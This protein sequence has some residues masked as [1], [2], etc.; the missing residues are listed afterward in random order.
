MKNLFQFLL[1]LLVSF[2]VCAAEST[3]DI[4]AKLNIALKNKAHYVRLKEERIL[5]FKKIKSD[6]LSKEQEYNYNKTLY[7]E[8]QKFNSDSAILYVKKNLK[9]AEELQN[10]DLAN[11][12]NL[13]LVTLY[14]SSG[15]YRESEA[16][17]K[18]IDKKSLSKSLLQNYYV[19]YREFFEHMLPT[20][21]M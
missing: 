10:K 1:I 8:Y 5:N 17:L 6:D 4:I 19:A 20:A 16:I 18:S 12:A 13:Q 14:S 3:D 9:I 21:T 2:P 11:L 7:T 15:K